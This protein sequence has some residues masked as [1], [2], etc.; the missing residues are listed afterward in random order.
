MNCNKYIFVDYE[1]TLSE[2][3]RGS[4]KNGEVLLSDL[5]F[6]DVFTQLKPNEQVRMYLL[7]QNTENIYVLGVVDTN[8]EIEQKEQWLK[9]HYPWIKPE[10][11][12]FISGEHKKVEVIDEYVKNKRLDKKEVILIDDKQNHLDAVIRAGYRGIN[13][14]DLMIDK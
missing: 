7:H 10:N 6:G 5:L 13:A 9:L 12:I 8:R 14:L 1:G 4:G 11:Y 2:T 3:P